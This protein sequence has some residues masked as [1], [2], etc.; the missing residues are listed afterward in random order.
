MRCKDAI[1]HNHTVHSYTQQIWRSVLRLGLY[2]RSRNA[3]YR[4]CGKSSS[5]VQQEQCSHSNFVFYAQ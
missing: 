1:T 3:G 4:H 2:S 5:L